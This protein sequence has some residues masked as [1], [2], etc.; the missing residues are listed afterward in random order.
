MKTR[1]ILV[2]YLAPILMS[3]FVLFTGN[4][5]QADKE[6][7]QDEALRLRLEGKVVSLET[8]L[9]KAKAHYSGNVLEA[10]LE[11]K[12]G[13]YIYEIEILDENG[14]VWELKYDAS[15]AILLSTEK[16]D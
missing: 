3:V 8:I 14:T 11:K 6:H 7:E 5:A 15:T 4:Y 2:K 10:E 16:E 9:E 13:R 1:L 12:R